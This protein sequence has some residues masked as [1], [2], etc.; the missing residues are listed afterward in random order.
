LPRDRRGEVNCLDDTTTDDH[1]TAPN[2]TPVAPAEE[3]DD[4]V[5]KAK[6]P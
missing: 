3:T 6:A 5:T 1:K 4:V 2:G